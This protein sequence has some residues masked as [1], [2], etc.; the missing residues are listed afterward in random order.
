MIEHST[1]KQA[2]H[3]SKRRARMLPVLAVIF[4]AQQATYFRST[5]APPDR[6]TVDHVKIGAWLVLSLVMLAALTTNGFWLQP[7]AKCAT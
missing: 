6:R 3:L 5:P 7:Q 1:S 2:E 4:S